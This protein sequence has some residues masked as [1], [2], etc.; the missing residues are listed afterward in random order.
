MPSRLWLDGLTGTLC[1]FA[2]LMRY[3]SLVLAVY[4]ACVILWQSRL[5]LSI[6]TRR[7]GAFG[8]GFLPP[9]TFQAY[10][11][12]Y[13]SNVPATPGGLSLNVMPVAVHQRLWD[14]ALLL[15]TANYSWAFWVPGQA[16][17]LLF[18]EAAGAFPWQLGI[19]LLG[20]IVVAVAVKTHGR[21]RIAALRDHR[22]VA[23]GLFVAVPL[24][25][26]GCEILGQYQYV[27][28]QRYYW[29][30]VPLSVFVA[31]SLASRTEIP[32]ARRA[33]RVLPTLCALY[34]TS[35]MAMSLVYVMFLPVPGTIGRSQRSRLMGSELSDWPSTAVIYERSLAR[36]FVMELLED[37]PE[38]LL[39]T[40]K[41][42]WFY[43]DPAVDASKLCELD[44]R[45]LRAT[46]VS[47][48][49]RIVILTFDEGQP[50]D[51]W[52]YSGNGIGGS[53][54]RAN[55][56]ERL[57]DLNVLRRFP[58]EGIKVLEAR[59]GAGERVILKPQATTH[60]RTIVP[61]NTFA[62]H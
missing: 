36:R 8:L 56:F 25:L 7:W 2:L 16:M 48:P 29:P 31:Y 44:C 59:V 51:L 30:L 6:L 46:Y 53:H 61:S 4:A 5:R 3:A 19:A 58:E 34:L 24:T 47:G 13:L 60:H 52:Y 21:N 50:L 20:L 9:L 37:R 42:G 45:I 1:G 17:T 40:S 54:L 41:A 28:D 33:T 23:L 49:A 35:Y 39:L 15:H 14:G 32:N 18:P 38:T 22:I 26:L 55:C 11:N 27:S 43:W 62:L 12:Y 10:V 57:S